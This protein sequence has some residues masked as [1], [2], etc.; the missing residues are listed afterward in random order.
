MRREYKLNKYISVQT[1]PEIII[2]YNLLSKVIFGLSKEKY[3]LLTKTIYQSWR[4][5]L[6]CYS[7]Q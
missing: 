4:L 6:L 3:E 1:R 5:V 7:A 2:I